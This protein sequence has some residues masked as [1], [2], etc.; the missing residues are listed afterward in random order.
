MDKMDKSLEIYNLW[1][2]NQEESE[3]LN[4]LVTTREIEAVIRRLLAHKSPGQDGFT[5][6]FY[7]PFKEEL[8]PTLLKLLQ[9]IQEEGRLTNPFYDASIILIPK[10]GKDTTKKENYRPISLMNIDAKILNKILAKQIQQYIKKI[11]HHDE[12]RFILRMQG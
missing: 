10:P 4:R 11:K 6:E 1:K 2:L 12:V 9:K 7:Q 5:G 8:T 3:N